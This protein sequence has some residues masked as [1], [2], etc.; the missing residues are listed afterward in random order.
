MKPLKPIA[1]RA[2]RITDSFN[3]WRAKKLF[4]VGEPIDMDAVR[5]QRA[6]L[7]RQILAL[8]DGESDLPAQFRA[9]QADWRSAQPCSS[10]SAGSPE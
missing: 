8:P 5:A 9:W 3:R 10:K 2:R 7:R 6:E 1:W 4:V